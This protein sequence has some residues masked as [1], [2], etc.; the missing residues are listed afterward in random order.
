MNERVDESERGASLVDGTLEGG[1]Q[2]LYTTPIDQF[3]NEDVADWN[4]GSVRKC[5]LEWFN[6][7]DI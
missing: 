3:R 5:Q 1:V 7:E 4:S 2:D 6:W